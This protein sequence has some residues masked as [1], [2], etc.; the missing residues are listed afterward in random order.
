LFLFIHSTQADFWLISKEQNHL[1][2]R[3]N[4]ATLWGPFLWMHSDLHPHCNG[5]WSLG[6]HL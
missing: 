5:L 1:L 4:I 6:D 3:M 2:C